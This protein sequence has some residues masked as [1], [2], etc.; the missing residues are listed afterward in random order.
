MRKNKA[1]YLALSAVLY[2]LFIFSVDFLLGIMGFPAESFAQLRYKPNEDRLIKNIEF[3]Y[4][5]VTNQEGFRYRDIPFKK[6]KKN[7]YRIVVMGDSFVEGTGVDGKDVFTSR[8]EQMF[9][10]DGSP[11]EFINLGV[12]GADPLVYE[13]LLFSEGIRYE[14]DGVLIC[15]YANDLFGMSGADSAAQVALK[16]KLAGPQKLVRQLW[17]HLY[18]LIKRA[19]VA[20]KNPARLQTGDFKTRIAQIARENK[21]PELKIKQWKAR[22]SD[23]LVEAAERGEFNGSI[24]YSG[25][26]RPD[27]WATSL[28]IN[29]PLA[30]EK[31]RAMQS[32]LNRMIQELRRRGMEAAVVYIPVQ[33]Q[34]DAS[35]HDPVKQNPW[36]QSGVEIK[37]QWLTE[38][39]R[40][41]ARLRGWAKSAEVP[42]L[43]LTDGLRTEQARRGNLV[44]PLD[45][46]WTAEG[47][48]AAAKAIGTWIQTRHLFHRAE[49]KRVNQA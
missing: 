9:S 14:P 42:F 21:I 20:Y 5:L 13:K 23:E 34:Y 33:F 3:S 37:K 16:E 44:W 12:A 29:T 46:H 8:L 18:A 7:H 36:V 32:L 28:D 25:L 2:I 15:L 22:I 17:P 27:Y 26:L 45:G 41:Q 10:K 40:L 6:P 38:E 4:R 24:L 48:Q 49:T 39:S 43:D 35:A 19:Y 11:V 1:G 47:H 31:W 30:E